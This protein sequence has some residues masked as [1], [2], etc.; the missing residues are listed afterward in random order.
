[1]LLGR[2]IDAQTVVDWN[3]CSRLVETADDTG[4]DPFASTNTLAGLLC[5][6]LDHNLLSLPLGN[7]TACYFVN[8]VRD[9]R[10]KQ[11]LRDV[12]HRETSRVG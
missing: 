2:K 7:Q 3:I 4:D 9:S 10:R 1:M 12:C 11:F 5:E 8:L 6:Q